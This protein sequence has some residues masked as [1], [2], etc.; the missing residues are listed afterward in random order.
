[1]LQRLHGQKGLPRELSAFALI[2]HDN[3]AVPRV[4]ERRFLLGSI[5]RAVEIA[6]AN[7]YKR[8]MA[9]PRFE[10]ILTRIMVPAA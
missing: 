5:R 6:G 3:S 8:V 4:L 9:L 2:V 1:M 10:L 7:Q